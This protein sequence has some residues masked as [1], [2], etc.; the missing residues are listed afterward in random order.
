MK[1]VLSIENKSQININ[2]KTKEQMNQ[3]NQMKYAKKTKT[4]KQLHELALH[5][6]II[7]K[8]SYTI[9][10]YYEFINNNY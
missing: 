7:F 6:F 5:K 9:Y 8:K 10:G 2:I 4:K 1:A 3:M